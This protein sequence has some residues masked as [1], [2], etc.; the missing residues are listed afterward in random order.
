M[1]SFFFF[2]LDFGCHLSTIRISSRPCSFVCAQ[3]P[4]DK[5]S[6]HCF[7]RFSCPSSMWRLSALDT[8][9]LRTSQITTWK[10]KTHCRFPSPFVRPSIRLF[11]TFDLTTSYSQNLDSNDIVTHSSPFCP[12]NPFAHT[13]A[14][15]STQ[16][17]II[18]VHTQRYS[19]A[20]RAERRPRRQYTCNGQFVQTFSSPINLSDT[21]HCSRYDV[22]INWTLL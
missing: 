4:L 7:V 10:C 11:A 14:F 21:R 16:I 3:F 5:F 19:F 1:F 8:R 15:V 6:L 13:P 20:T 18:I 22:Y 12:Q 2:L 17:I 9:T